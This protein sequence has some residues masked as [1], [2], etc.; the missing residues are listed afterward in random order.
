MPRQHS[1]NITISAASSEMNLMHKNHCRYKTSAAAQS[2]GTSMTAIYPARS[3][4]FLVFLENKSHHHYATFVTFFVVARRV[5]KSTF[6]LLVRILMPCTPSLDFN[7]TQ[8]QYLPDALMVVA[9]KHKCCIAELPL[10]VCLPK[11]YPL[12]P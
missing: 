8:P 1:T 4:Q 9:R 12:C 2:T 6:F 10:L 11:L 7:L 5:G 3:P